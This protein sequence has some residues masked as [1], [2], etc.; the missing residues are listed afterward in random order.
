[1]R[2]SRDSIIHKGK[3]WY[4]YGEGFVLTIN[5]SSHSPIPKRR[6]IF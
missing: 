2:L 1:M 3:N 4:I 5:A 6:F